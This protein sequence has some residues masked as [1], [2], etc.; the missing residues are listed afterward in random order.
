MTGITRCLQTVIVFY[1]IKPKD[2]R[3][4]CG[5]LTE[6]LLTGCNEEVSSTECIEA[7]RNAR[8]MVGFTRFGFNPVNSIVDSI[9][10]HLLI[11]C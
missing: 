4:P 7:W 9:W 8:L 3:L 6:K 5:A 2:G 11:F 10:H 1:Q